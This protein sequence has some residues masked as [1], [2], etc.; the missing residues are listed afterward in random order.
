M[1]KMLILS[2]ALLFGLSCFANATPVTFNVDG[3]P[4]SYVNL[5][6]QNTGFDVLYWTV[7]GNTTL[8]VALNPELATMAPFTLLDGESRPLDF[9]DFSVTG[10]GIG[11][12]DLEANLSFDSPELNANAN[13]NG[14]WGTVSWDFG[15]LGSGS[16][17]A[18]LFNWDQS[19]FD[20]TL[21]DGNMVQ[22]ALQ[23]GFA[24][25]CN[26]FTT[27]HATVTNLG[28]A[29]PVPEP[30]TLLLLG[31]GLAGLAFYRR[32]KMK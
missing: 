28:G 16:F 20:F 1:K 25:G 21:A 3:S 32:K 17:S 27:V 11:S 19:V 4:D 6:N 14:G 15:L 8:S 31:S 18:G 10:S 26:D 12:F 5:S 13:G 30:G 9:F 7:G 29:A 24:I 2:F 22:I 23:D